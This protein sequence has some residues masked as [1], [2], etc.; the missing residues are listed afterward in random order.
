MIDSVHDITVAYRGGNIPEYE[1]KFLNGQLPDEIH[2]YFDIYNINDIFSSN[3]SNDLLLEN[4]L[5]ER[6]MKKE[7][8]LKWYLIFLYYY[9]IDLFN[10]FLFKFKK[11]LQ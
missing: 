9:F 11:F 6:W 1:L 3:E 4:W 7:N 8:F 5:N 10:F 2:F